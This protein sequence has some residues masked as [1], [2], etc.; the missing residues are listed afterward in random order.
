MTY[1]IS[2]PADF[3]NIA[4]L[5]DLAFHMTMLQGFDRQEAEHI[6]CI[7]DELATNAIEYGSQ[8][9]SEVNLELDADSKQVKIICS[10]Q[11]HGNRMKA[12]EIEKKIREPLPIGAN[13]GRGI[14]LIVKNFAQEFDLRDREGGGIIATAVVKKSISS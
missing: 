2:F 4:P 11:G 9:T 5:R 14:S 10:D 12:V 1:K 7:V 3:K 6:R 13:R 8:K